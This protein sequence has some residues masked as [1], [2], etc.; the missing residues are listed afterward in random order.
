MKE[1]AVEEFLRIE[2]VANGKQLLA[3]V[4]SSLLT[5]R[6]CD[7]LLQV[8]GITAG[9]ASAA[10]LSKGRSSKAGRGGEAFAVAGARDARIMRRR[11]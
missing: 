5:R 7:Q 4:M 1:H 2:T 10:A 11:R 8:C 6:V 3:G 9:S